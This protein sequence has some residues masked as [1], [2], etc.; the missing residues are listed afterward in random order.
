M[1]ENKE[2]SDVEK[3]YFSRL[4]RPY[5][6]SWTDR[7]Q[8][9]LK[10]QRLK[11]YFEKII[12]I[13]SWEKLNILDIGCASG[14]NIALLTQ[15][16]NNKIECNFIG[17][18]LSSTSISAANIWKNI[19]KVANCEFYAGDSNNLF[20]NSNSF[21]IVICLEVLEHL[22]VPKKAIDEIYRVL[23]PGGYAIIS[24]PSGISFQILLKT[25]LNRLQCTQLVLYIKNRLRKAVYYW[26][27]T[28]LNKDTTIFES[29]GYGHIS[30]KKPA[31]WWKI[32]KESGFMVKKTRSCGTL[33]YGG[34]WFDRHYWLF[35]FLYLVGNLFSLVPRGSHLAYDIM[36]LLKKPNE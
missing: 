26:A 17:V 23:K 31:V 33:V 22:Q 19:N 20:F 9:F 18:D 27:D 6:I 16:I 13:T 2:V 25:L 36:F 35:S 4:N 3:M 10:L 12:K 29:V 14:G 5:W 8:L 1:R 28:S 24:T 7:L 34:A 11:E 32:F 30:V 15:Y 21:D